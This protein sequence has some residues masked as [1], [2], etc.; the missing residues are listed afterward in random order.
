M[1]ESTLANRLSELPDQVRQ[2]IFRFMSHPIADAMKEDKAQAILT[3]II[4]RTQGPGGPK[5]IPRVAYPVKFFLFLSGCE[6]RGRLKLEQNLLYKHNCTKYCLL[7]R[8]FEQQ[9]RQTLRNRLE[10]QSPPPPPSA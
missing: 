9:Q 8:Y 1:D 6:E 2:H 5:R 3:G 4:C 10:L 7:R